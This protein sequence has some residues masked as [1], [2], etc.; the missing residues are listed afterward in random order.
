MPYR[1]EEAL[2][3][4][5]SRPKVTWVDS[6][7]ALRVAVTQWPTV[8]GLDTEFIRTNTFYPKPGLYQI[9]ADDRVYLIDPLVIDDWQ[10]FVDYLQDDSTVK[11]MHACQ[12]D[13]ELLHHHL[14]VNP[15]GLFDTQ[16]ANA[17][18]TE[19]FSLSYA[20]LV[21]ERTGLVIDKHE[22]RS[23]WLQRPLTQEQVQYAVEDVTCLLDLYEQLTSLLKDTGREQWFWS[24]MSQRAQYAPSDPQSAYRNVKKA[25]KLKGRQL[26]ALQALCAWREETAR[27]RNVPRSRVVWDEHIYA[28]ACLSELTVRH[29]REVLPRGIARHYDEALVLQHQLGRAGSVPESLPK[30]LSSAQTKVLKALRQV[31]LAKASQL[32]IAPELIARKK[33][34]EHCIRHYASSLGLPEHY[35]GWRGELLGTAFLEI[36]QEGNREAL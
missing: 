18:L 26:G 20:G 30:P 34:L 28:F 25:W 5:A 9:A 36:L 22:T 29:V 1:G 35:T 7:D 10:P 11:V 21:Q 33:D 3:D 31:S 8:I 17:Y 12:E 27:A 24:D 15:G 32:G 14:G 6:N 13:L 23:N 16:F 4:K 2:S 19:N